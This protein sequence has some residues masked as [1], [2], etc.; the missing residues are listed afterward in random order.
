MKFKYEF[1][2]GLF[3]LV[4]LIVFAGSILVLGRERHLFADQVAYTTTFRDVKGLAPGAPVRLGG[5]AIGRVSGIQFAKN[6]EDPNVYVGVLINSEFHDR[7]RTD[8]IA[9]IETQGLLG[10]RYL[11]LRTGHN[12]TLLP[13]GAALQSDEPRDFGEAIQ[14]AGSLVE[15]VHGVAA[16]VRSF[17]ERL[18]KGPLRELTSSTEHLSG[19]L[20]EIEHGRGLLHAVIYDA[21]GGETLPAL[22]SAAAKIGS[23]GDGI[24]TLASDVKNSRGLMHDL[25]YGNPQQNISDLIASLNRSASHIE[26]ITRSVAQGSGTLG[27][28]LVDSKLYDNMVQVTDDAKRSLILRY[29]IRKSL[30]ASTSKPSLGKSTLDKSAKEY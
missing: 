4:T 26:R 3:V 25:I 7:I 30:N 10:D 20:N 9:T 27:A 24:A 13:A 19:I 18:E 28:L 6:S 11:S 2:A 16:D 22:N 5:I 17:F 8:S 29:A 21:R 12:P 14:Q 15:E 23:A 1:Q